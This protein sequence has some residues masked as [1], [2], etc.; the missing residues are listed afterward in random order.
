[1]NFFRNLPGELRKAGSID[2]A[3]PWR[4]LGQIILPI[5]LPSVAT[6]TLFVVVYHWDE[7]FNGL[8]LMNKSVNYPLQT[9]IQL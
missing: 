9:Y 2:G 6:I 3:G 7:F 4:I 8:V 1:M 5:S